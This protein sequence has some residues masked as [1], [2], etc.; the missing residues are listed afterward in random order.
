MARRQ[1][2]RYM[3]LKAD[4]I[5]ASATGQS[6][7][8]AAFWSSLLTA[9]VTMLPRTDDRKTGGLSV[10][11]CAQIIRHVAEFS[12]HRSVAEIA[13][14]RIARAAEGDGNDMTFLPG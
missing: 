5:A 7:P 12:D 3:Y 4:L 9:V 6:T 14:G 11:Q 10:S 8:G 1:K 13:R 2:R